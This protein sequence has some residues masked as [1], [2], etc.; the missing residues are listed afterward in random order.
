M[1][2]IRTEADIEG[3][4]RVRGSVHLPMV[5]TRRVYDPKA[6]KKVGVYLTV[7]LQGV[8]SV[9]DGHAPGRPMEGTALL[10]VNPGGGAVMEQAMEVDQG[11]MH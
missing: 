5:H 11:G 10:A 8:Q 3:S 1:L 4:G 6:N 9:T 2:D 7:G